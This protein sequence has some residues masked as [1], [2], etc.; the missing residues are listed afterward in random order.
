MDAGAHFFK[1]DFQVHSPR[2]TNW[3]GTRAVSQEEREEYAGRFVLAC[4]QRGL[5]A[6][7]I[8]DHHDFGF[9]PIIKATAAAE[10]DDEGEPVPEQQRLVVFPGMEL[11]LG[12]GCQAIL[13]LDA[14]FPV[15]FLG[16]VATK[17]GIECNVPEEAKHAP[18]KRLDHF[19]E[20]QKLHNDLDQLSSVKGKYIVLPNVSNGGASTLQR[21]GWSAQYRGMPCVGGYLDHEIEKL[22]DG[23]RKILDGKVREYDFKPLGLF[24]TSDN[25]HDDFSLLGRNVAWVKWATPTA[26]ALRQA[27]LARETRIL[28][29]APRLPMLVV[30]SMR[31]SQSKFL[32]PIN[33]ELNPQ[34]NCVI[35]GRGT[36]KST[37]LEYLR[38]GLCDQP[39]NTDEDAARYQQK[40][41]SLVENTLKSLSSVVTIDF[42]VNGVPHVIR[43]Q[44][45]TGETLLKVGDGDYAS[46]A[47]DDVREILPLQAYSQKQL[48]AV[49]I[50]QEELVRFVEAPIA[51]ALSENSSQRE[52]AV[53]RIRSGHSTLRRK[54]QLAKEIARQE[55]ELASLEK[56]LVEL[57]KGFS[58][59]SE[60][61]QRVLADQGVFETQKSAFE[62][63]SRDIETARASV[64]RAVTVL[65]SLPSSAP[66][67]GK[68]GSPEAF[69]EAHAKI[70][71]GFAGAVER[72]E[73]VIQGLSDEDATIREF[74]ALSAVW[75]T[76][77]EQQAVAY[78]VV[79][80]KAA[81]HA[82]LLQR[83]SEVRGS[84][85]AVRETIATRRATL[86]EYGN[87]EET[88]EQALAQLRF[89]AAQR[90]DAIA[91]RCNDVTSL[92]DGVI[93]ATLRAGGGVGGVE[94]R[95]LAVLEG[96]GI[97][98]QTEK[99]A[100]ICDIIRQDTSGETWSKLLS[101]LE[102]LAEHGP[103]GDTAGGA[104]QLRGPTLVSG[105]F[106]A[107][108]IAKLASRLS[109]SDWLELTLTPL[110]DEPHFEYR[111]GQHDY[112]PFADA[113]AGQQA[114]ALLGVL[115]AQPGP[116]LVIDQ[117]EDD[118]DNQVILDVVRSV[119]KAKNRRQ[120]IF[121][122]HN[123]CSAARH[124][125]GRRVQMRAACLA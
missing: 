4:R 92:S 94:A 99:V 31:V 106:A 76:Q 63:W 73:A 20:F 69:A 30:K 77:Y 14:D 93:K 22:G 27:C 10:L 120:I 6:V 16:N 119:W 48:S 47:E 23:D 45:T 116:P 79:E 105:G 82:E 55:I 90:R 74:H 8:T 117:P 65:Q 37:I 28:H 13:I 110:Q 26:E 2:D 56:Q 5:N 43:R 41:T 95:L 83:A 50:R 18:T 75:R 89:L 124:S 98:N 49:G 85:A 19:T 91:G 53:A 46:V 78:G 32:G 58:D 54:R 39:A 112:V 33:L 68:A 67:P 21:K 57:Q 86:T 17:L 25:R 51:K 107:A 104:H 109:P 62:T 96:S 84:I 121:S 118:L 71:L 66:S 114:T 115:L 36:G 11:T 102:E 7:A 42:L 87:P 100:S 122:T 3:H 103:D 12:I 64:T 72:L 44:A 60:D 38:W 15:E 113:S 29:S 9:F 1:C 108:D 59:L 35:G 97:R 61:E 88:Y 40:S 111:L 70:K 101:E 80:K 24:P 123:A 81:A 34:F 125:G 52:D